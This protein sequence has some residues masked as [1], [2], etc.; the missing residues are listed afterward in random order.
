MNPPIPI[1]EPPPINPPP[2]ANLPSPINTNT[3]VPLLTPAD[4]LPPEIP[5]AQAQSQGSSSH[6]GKIIIAAIFLLLIILFAGGSV[7]A[8]YN[9]YKILPIPKTAQ[10][11][12]D[13]IIMTTPLPKTPRII[14]AKTEV[15]MASVKSAVTE[16][17]FKFETKSQNFPIRNGTITIKGPIDFKTQTTPR[18]Q[19]DISGSIAMEGLQLSAAASVKH[20]DD[21]LYF[22]VTEFPGGSLVS[23]ESIKNQ[24]FYTKD[25]TITKEKDNT[26]QIKKLES[27]IN[28]F[29]SDSKSWSTIQNSDGELYKLSI[30]P[31]KDEIAKLIFDIINIAEPIDQ[32]TVKNSLDLEKIREF[33]NKIQDLEVALDINKN[34]GLISQATVNIPIKISTPA[35]L[36]QLGQVNLSPQTPLEF[37]LAVT[38]K[39]SNYNQPVIVEIPQDAKDIKDYTKSL[40]NSLPKDFGLPQESTPGAAEDLQNSLPNLD[41]GNSNS[42]NNELRSLLD[43]SQ[44]QGAKDSIWNLLLRSLSGK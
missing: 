20:I 18:S 41:D 21:T 12:I 29:V 7:A 39:F 3:A 11:I 9:D 15:G 10:N 4:Q 23:A 24:W 13:S 36:S 34:D 40:E 16:T 19:F 42:D 28:Q 43:N 32:S 35:G 31:P 14:L 17:E 33:T 1:D 6:K 8:A 2:P 27:R 37:K 22:M 44:I 30:K 26:E 25:Q 38:T 5:F